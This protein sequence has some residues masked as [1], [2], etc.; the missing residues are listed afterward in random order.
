M[1]QVQPSALD[2][3]VCT[4]VGWNQE[5]VML[6]RL[7]GPRCAKFTGYECVYINTQGSFKSCD[8]LPCQAM[9]LSY[10]TGC[11]LYVL[12]EHEAA[13]SLLFWSS[14]ASV[15]TGNTASF[16]RSV[17]GWLP[18]LPGRTSDVCFFFFLFFFLQ[19]ALTLVSSLSLTWVTREQ[20]LQH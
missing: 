14:W 9:C 20:S 11:I 3:S 19:N 18:V 12:L 17:V 8:V 6:R 7:R 4:A 2:G 16:A 13:S 10:L 5:R 1:K 15:N